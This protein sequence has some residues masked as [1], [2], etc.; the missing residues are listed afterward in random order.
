MAYKKIGKITN[1]LDKIG[2]AVLEIETGSVKTGDTLL[3]GEE[4]EGF[5]Q[6][7]GSMQIEHEQVDEVKKGQDCGLKVDRVVKKG[8]K[9]YKVV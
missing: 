8:L 7:V 1:Y 3:M 4:G 6:K 5:E 9:V 2:V